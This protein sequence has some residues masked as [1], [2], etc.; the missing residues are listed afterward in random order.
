MR[1]SSKWIT[2]SLLFIC[3]GCNPAEQLTNPIM[4]PNKTENTME[5]ASIETKDPA[6]YQSYID[7]FEK[8][9]T[10]MN[11]NYYKDIDRKEFDRFINVFNTKIYKE[12]E[13]TGKS[14]DFVRW[15]SAAYL[16]DFLKQKDDIFSA[17]YPPEPAKEYEA[18]ALGKKVDLGIE[19][20][21]IMQGYRVKFVE[22]RSDAYEK[23][24]KE[25]DL[26]LSIDGT[27]SDSLT[28]ERINELLTPLEGSTISLV[29]LDG[30][31]Q[32]QHSIDLVSKEY[33]KQGV[34][35]V[36]IPV[37][38]LYCLQIKRFNRMTGEDMLRFIKYFSLQG[39]MKGL[40]IDLR[41]NPGGPPLAARE[42]SSF[43]LTGGD[44]FAYFQKKDQPKASLDVPVIPPE[45]HY[46]GPLVILID[47]GSGSASELF[48]GVLQNRKRAVLMGQNSAGQV[49][50]K[51]MFP[52]DD[53]SMILLVTARGYQPDGQVFS[54]NGLTPD[55]VINEQE[56]PDILK[57][58]VSYLIYMNKIQENINEKT[59]G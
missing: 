14:D 47:K 37:E 11:E 41:G 33:F 45:L 39:P 4:V 43:F 20:E 3:V 36:P 17:F 5:K 29:Y 25:N 6:T 26:V 58:A 59:D 55:R 34:F 56:Q 13:E 2:L 8:V 35:N 22:P 23:G 31:T 24:L 28:L 57:Y 30:T 49:F 38:N 53:K 42:I 48:S 51:S 32:Q 12:L 10:L 1:V 19:G 27:L 15:R 21:K 18:T 7:F 52:L 44:E 50:L 46:D 16:I 54:F 9:Y 40:I